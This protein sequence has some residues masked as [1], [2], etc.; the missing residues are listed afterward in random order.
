MAPGA[1]GIKVEPQPTAW[2][3]PAAYHEDDRRSHSTHGARESLVRIHANAFAEHFVGSMNSECLSRMIFF[4][5][6]PLQHAITH[7]T[8]HYDAE[9]NHQGLAN[10]LLRAAPIVAPSRSVHRRQRLGG[11]L[12]YFHRAAA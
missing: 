12:N 8:A 9:R 10:Q 4:G 7:F 6:A 1:G 11:M 3:G 2:A 5:Q